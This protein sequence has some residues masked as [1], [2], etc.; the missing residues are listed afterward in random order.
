MEDYL[1]AIHTLSADSARPVATSDLASMMGV[2]APSATNMVKALAAVGF[3]THTPYHGVRLTPDGE[4]I[5]LEV[6]RHHRLIER[7]LQESL[8]YGWD[9]VHDEA[10][11]L[12][13]AISERL[14]ER[15]AAA[16]GD[17]TIDPHGDPIP[18]REGAVIAPALVPLAALSPGDRAV[19]GRV[20]SADPEKLRYLGALGLVP[21]ATVELLER[22][23]FGGPVRLSVGGAERVVGPTLESDVLVTPAAT[24]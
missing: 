19:V 11:R 22:A 10:D 24:P 8:G 21:G 23:P 7:Y 6:I 4:R 18:S 15:L 13:H 20:A 16:L 9:E 17:P 5:A 3:V 14:E 12:E 1:K 2:S